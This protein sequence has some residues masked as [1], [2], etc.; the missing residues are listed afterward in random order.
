[1]RFKRKSPADLQKQLTDLKGGSGYVS[2]GTEWKITKDNA[3]NG[4]A[5]IR[6]LPQ[7]DDES[8]PFVKLISHSFKKNNK[9]YWNN[10]SSTFGDYDNCPVCKYLSENDSYNT[11]KSEYNDIKRRTSYWANILVIKDSAKPENEG[12][13]FKYRFGV[14]IMEKINAMVEVDAELGEVPVDVTCPY[15][16]A[17]LILKVKQVSG[18]DN[19]DESKFQASAEIKN[20]D[21]ESYQDKLFN[22]MHDIMAIAGKDKFEPLEKLQKIFDGVMK[23]NANTNA[24]KQADDLENELNNFNEEAEVELNEAMNAAPKT[25]PK[26]EPKAETK[27]EL[28]DDFDDLFD[29]LD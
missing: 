12:K 16:G 13:V 20:I 17:N 9:R 22:E 26:A 15:E 18:F 8:L 29:D 28:D 5:V 14:K 24:S 27:T 10:C 19:Y 11:N 21:D 2:D 6:F 25:K 1:M 23:Q 4:S 7:K 3:G